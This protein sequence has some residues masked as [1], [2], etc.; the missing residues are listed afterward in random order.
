VR[1]GVAAA[2]ALGGFGLPGAD[3]R[4]DHALVFQQL[5][6]QLLRRLRARGGKRSE[7]K[8]S[9]WAPRHQKDTGRGI[10]RAFLPRYTTA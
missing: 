1:A 6:L 4:L 10:G 3:A 7:R 8:G 9:P 5:A 2:A